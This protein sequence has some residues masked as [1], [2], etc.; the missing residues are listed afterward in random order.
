MKHPEHLSRFP[1]MTPWVGTNY[2]EHRIMVVCESHYMP[3]GSTINRDADHWYACTEGKLSEIE[4]SYID[5]VGCVEYRLSREGRA[6]LPNNAYVQIN[7]VVPFDRI[8]F[9]NFFYRPAVYKSNVL[10]VGITPQ[11]LRVAS[12][13]L[14]WFV[15]TH[16][17]RLVVVASASTAG[18]PASEVLKEMEVQYSVIH[19]PMARQ[20]KFAEQAV[21]VLNL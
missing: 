18:P 20:G 17:P 5:T 2:S 13:I 9:S 12:E 16:A 15:L 4:R 3:Q 7:N 21:Q 10:S 19:H 1:C 14:R 11:D 8:A 6:H